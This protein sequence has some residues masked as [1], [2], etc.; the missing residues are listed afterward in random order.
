[1]TALS[2][3][4]R[5]SQLNQPTDYRKAKTMMGMI[6]QCIG[7]FDSVRLGPPLR[8]CSN[9]FFLEKALKGTKSQ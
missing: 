2:L 4:E 3:I 5:Q 8:V 1:M 9:I 7:A 6:E